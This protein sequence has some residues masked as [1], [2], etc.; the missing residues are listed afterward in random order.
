MRLYKEKRASVKRPT[1]KFDIV[2]RKKVKAIQESGIPY[3]IFCPTA[4]METLP[5]FVR[6]KRATVIGKQPYPYHWF[7]ADDLARMVSASHGIKEAVNTRFFVHGPEEILTHEAVRRY[8]SVFHPEIKK[9]ST[10]PC[11]LASFIATV[12]RNKEMKFGVAVLDFFDKVGEGGDPTEANR[13]LG[14]PQ[15]T[16]DEWLTQRKATFGEFPA[17]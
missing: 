16:L 2:A 1:D 7:A 5:Q 3:A 14:A 6:G 9:V 12:T 4:S 15:T 11:W 8:C 13:I 17:R 10:I